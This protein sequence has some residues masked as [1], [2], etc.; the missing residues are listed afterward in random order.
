MVHLR[1]LYFQLHT[2]WRNRT[3][4]PDEAHLKG[5]LNACNTLFIITRLSDL[6]GRKGNALKGES[7]SY[8]VEDKNVYIMYSFRTVFQ[9]HILTCILTVSKTLA[10]LHF[11][12][13]LFSAICT[14]IIVSFHYGD[15]AG[16]L[17]PRP[18]TP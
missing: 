16:S 15:F 2:L 3:R 8:Y 4:S 5:R 13:F 11:V 12:S 10:L 6:N 17:Q 18:P 9:K 14:A 1:I 7:F